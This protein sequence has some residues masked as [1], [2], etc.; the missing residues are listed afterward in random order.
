MA[1]KLGLMKRSFAMIK[2]SMPPRHA[3]PPFLSRNKCARGERSQELAPAESGAQLLVPSLLFSSPPKYRSPFQLSY[4]LPMQEWQIGSRQAIFRL[5]C[6]S[7]I[8]SACTFRPDNF[9]L[10]LP[11]APPI[12]LPRSPFF[13]LQPTIRSARP[14]PPSRSAF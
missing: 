2:Y 1:D 6:Q 8:S 11:V 12:G 3:M 5:A 4:I 9:R 10:A 7:F 13:V 14:R